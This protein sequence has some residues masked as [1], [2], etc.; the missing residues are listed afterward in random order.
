MSTRPE[1]L[2]SSAVANREPLPGSRRVYVPGPGGMR[3][4]F[5]EIALQ[6]TR[7]L[8]ARVELNAPLRVYDTSGPYTDSG[9]DIDLHQGLPELRRE[10][11]D[12]RGTYETTPPRRSSAPDLALTRPRLALRG[13]GNVTQ[14]HYARKGIVTPE[15]EF[16]AIREGMSP[17]F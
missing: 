13:R 5:R 11:I 1:V 6:P 12:Q 2:P 9:I 7:G 3:V 17:E 15:M 4:P 10:W 14:M 16:V 8:Q